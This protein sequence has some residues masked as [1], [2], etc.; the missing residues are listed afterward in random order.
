MNKNVRLTDAETVMLRSSFVRIDNS[1]FEMHLAACMTSKYTKI[2]Q[3]M[4]SEVE[5]EVTPGK[6]DFTDESH[7]TLYLY[8]L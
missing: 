3:K 2:Y 4:E 5:F 7:V 1:E 6:P 8:V